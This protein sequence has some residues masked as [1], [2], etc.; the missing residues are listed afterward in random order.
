MERWK[1]TEFRQFLLYTGI[2]ALK[3]QISGVLY[4]LFLLLF[5]AIFCLSSAEVCNTHADYAH[6]LLCLFVREAGNLYGRGFFVYNEHGLTHLAEDVKN[7]GPLNSYSA[8]PF[9]NF[10]GQLK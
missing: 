5:V 3:G 7:F 6:E 2:I 9:E 4:N 10:L 8:F 1:A